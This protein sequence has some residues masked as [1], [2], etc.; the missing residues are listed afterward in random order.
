MIPRSKTQIQ[1]NRT[2]FQD[3]ADA[4]NTFV[5]VG[6]L[7]TGFGISFLFE[8]D[9]GLFVNRPTLLSFF[10]I[11]L[12]LTIS[13][14]GLGSVIMALEYYNM[15]KLL[16][17][18]ADRRLG[19]F[20]S[21]TSK[22]KNVGRWSIYISFMCLYASLALYIFAK[23]S[24]DSLVG[25]IFSVVIFGFA[26]LSILYASY[27]IKKTQKDL[28][29]NPTKYGHALNIDADGHEVDEQDK[30]AIAEEK[31]TNVGDETHA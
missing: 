8:Y 13:S 14:S 9:E 16:S 20:D 15:K 23:A 30:E 3:R 5:L 1:H 31:T 19:T 4:Y 11:L 18:Q 2:A 28:R 29:F 17:I 21:L 7:L 22:Y 10:L 27:K 24:G 6:T 12:S 26:F 25:T